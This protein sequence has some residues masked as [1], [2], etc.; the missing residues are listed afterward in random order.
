MPISYNDAR[1]VYIFTILTQLKLISLAPE[2]S[3]LNCLYV[4]IHYQAAQNKIQ[5][6][7]LNYINIHLHTI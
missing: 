7:H 4:W 6:F 2:E 1:E 3:D 5:T